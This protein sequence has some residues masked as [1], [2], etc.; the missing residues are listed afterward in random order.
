MSSMSDLDILRQDMERI[1]RLRQIR[2]ELGETGGLCNPLWE[3]E[4]TLINQV[5]QSWTT[6]EIQYVLDSRKVNQ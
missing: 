4:E 5:L 1:E 6:E 2:F 3:V